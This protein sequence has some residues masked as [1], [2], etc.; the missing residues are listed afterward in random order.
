MARSTKRPG[1]GERSRQDRLEF[2]SPY[3]TLR[4]QGLLFIGAFDLLLAIGV[5]CVVA[6][7]SGDLSGAAITFVLVATFSVFLLVLLQSL[8]LFARF[9]DEMIP[10]M[11][12]RVRD[13][14]KRKSH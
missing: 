7:L 12:R 2:R 6:K 3:A 10:H 14:L 11:V 9:G 5:L 1:N 4:G 8:L 13:Y